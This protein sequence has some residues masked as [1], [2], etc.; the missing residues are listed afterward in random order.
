[1]AFLLLS[2]RKLGSRQ[3]KESKGLP[4]LSPLAPEPHSWEK[5]TTINFLKEKN[6]FFLIS[7]KQREECSRKFWVYLEAG[8]VLIF[9]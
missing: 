9:S 5:A 1:M 2:Y 4:L 7:G 8:H 3:Q 6:S